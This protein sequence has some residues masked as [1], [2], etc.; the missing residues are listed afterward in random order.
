MS[1]PFGAWQSPINGAAIAS[2]VRLRD[3]QWDSGGDTLVWLESRGG[4]GVLQAQTGSDAPRDLTDRQL[5]VA[6]RV[7]Y[8]GGAFALGDGKVV[9]AAKG[10]L[11]S[12]ALAGGRA[13]RD[14]AAIWRLRGPGGLPGWPLGRLRP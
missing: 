5:N 12:Q 1:E 2:G 7:G 13:T 9:F 4:V 6:G 11:Y 3:V 10:R 8:G 14:H